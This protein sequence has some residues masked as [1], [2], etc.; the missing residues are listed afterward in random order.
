MTCDRGELEDKGTERNSYAVAADRGVPEG[1]WGQLLEQQ[2]GR[3]RCSRQ[4]AVCETGR[5]HDVCPVI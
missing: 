2:G 1:R 5:C 3:K 4:R